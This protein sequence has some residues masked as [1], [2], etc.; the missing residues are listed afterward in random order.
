MSPQ[1]RRLDDERALEELFAQ[2]CGSTDGSQRRVQDG[3]PVAEF[4]GFFEPASELL[5]TSSRVGCVGRANLEPPSPV[6]V[7]AVDARA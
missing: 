4:F 5:E 6:V 7:E 3:D 1:V 2:L